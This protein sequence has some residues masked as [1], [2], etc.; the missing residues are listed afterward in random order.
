M[1][2]WPKIAGVSNM[3]LISSLE[4]TTLTSGRFFLASRPR[5]VMVRT[6]VIPKVIRSEV[7]SLL[8]QNGTQE[9]T[10]IKIHGP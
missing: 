5:K 7:A 3:L 6:V 4:L 9:M 10:T 8:S 1:S 2:L